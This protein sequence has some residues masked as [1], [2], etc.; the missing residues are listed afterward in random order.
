MYE[1]P[2]LYPY[3]RNSYICNTDTPNRSGGKTNLSET[4][5]QEC[6]MFLINICLCRIWFREWS[7]RHSIFSYTYS[8]LVG[9]MH[10]YYYSEHTFLQN[11]LLYTSSKRPR[12]VCGVESAEHYWIFLFLNLLE[13]EMLLMMMMSSIMCNIQHRISYE[14]HTYSTRYVK[15]GIWR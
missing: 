8:V 10:S 3:I 15:R 14:N 12:F 5:P 13:W 2:V 6:F 4:Y 9:N 7:Y 1:T 11:I